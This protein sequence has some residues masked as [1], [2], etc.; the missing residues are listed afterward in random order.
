MGKKRGAPKKPREMAKAE[1]LQIRLNVAEKQAFALAAELDGKKVAEWIRDRLRK[2]SRK[3]IEEAGFAV[4]F[5]PKPD[6]QR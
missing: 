3:E 4:P 2:I 6:N 5:V 1:V